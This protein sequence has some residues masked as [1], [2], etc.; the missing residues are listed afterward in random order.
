[1]LRECAVVVVVRFESGF[2]VGG[3]ARDVIPRSS[4]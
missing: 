2:T 4:E 3:Y 1:M